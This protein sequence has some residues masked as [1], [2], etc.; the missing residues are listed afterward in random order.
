MC[1]LRSGPSL[2]VFLTKLNNVPTVSTALKPLYYYLNPLVSPLTL[3]PLLPLSFSLSISLSLPPPSYIDSCLIY[4]FTKRRLICKNLKNYP[5]CLSSEHC[6]FVRFSLMQLSDPFRLVKMCPLSFTQTQPLLVFCCF[7]SSAS[8]FMN[9]I[10]D[11]VD[12][13]TFIK[14]L[15]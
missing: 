1:R 8:C 3:C 12:A 2:T 4:S 10:K 6:S 5:G 7:L 9:V 11:E 14:V 13:E 15:F